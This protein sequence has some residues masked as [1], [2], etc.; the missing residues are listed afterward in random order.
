MT[1]G[2]GGIDVNG[3]NLM[4]LEGIRE[5]YGEYGASVVICSLMSY[6][7][8]AYLPTA[9]LSAREMREFHAW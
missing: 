5:N 8:D 6:R 2:N 3:D 4:L 9:A 7:G 1:A